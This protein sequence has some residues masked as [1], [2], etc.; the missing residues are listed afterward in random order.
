LK[1]LVSA[2]A[3][4]GVTSAVQAEVKVKYICLNDGRYWKQTNN[5]PK[6]YCYDRKYYTEETM[7]PH[8]RAYFEEQ[9]RRSAAIRAELEESRAKSLKQ[10]QEMGVEPRTGRGAGPDAR[11]LHQQRAAGRPAVTS[12]SGGVKFNTVEASTKPEPVTL[13]RDLVREI[14]PGTEREA[15]IAKLG[16]PHGRVAGD[17]SGAESWTYVVDGGA[18]AKIKLERGMVVQV[19]VP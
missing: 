15:V 13:S 9:T 3:L 16:E 14:E 5:G 10:M 11:S 1:L 2:V 12:R 4:L 19:I 6:R 7:P 17:S 18:F 8:V